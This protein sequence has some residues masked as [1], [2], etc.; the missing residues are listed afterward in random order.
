[1][2]RIPSLNKE[3]SCFL[4][5][6][7]GNLA[8]V[9]YHYEG[10]AIACVVDNGI[11]LDCYIADVWTQ[12]WSSKLLRKVDLKLFF[13]VHLW[14][15]L[16]C[17]PLRWPGAIYHNVGVELNL[18]KLLNLERWSFFKIIRTEYDETWKCRR[19]CVKIER[20]IHLLGVVRV[21][22]SRLWGICAIDV[23]IYD[24]L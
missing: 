17:M 4:S 6:F 2:E 12:P 7:F 24:L 10:S 11:I 9:C 8:R 14:A 18:G 23:E 16:S 19:I 15:T 20:V 13:R 22:Y 3:S 5:Q 21:L 1:M